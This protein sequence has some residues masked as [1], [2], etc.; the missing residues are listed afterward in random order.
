[1]G[2]FEDYVQDGVNWVEVLVSLEYLE[3]GV[4]LENIRMK[5]SSFLILIAKL[6]YILAQRLS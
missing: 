3:L 4:N 5:L 6:L 1:M 2:C